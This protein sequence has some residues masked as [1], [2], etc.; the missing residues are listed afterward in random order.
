M[1]TSEKAVTEVLMPAEELGSRDGARIAAN[2]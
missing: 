2:G 1:L